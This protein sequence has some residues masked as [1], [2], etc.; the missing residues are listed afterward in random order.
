[1]FGNVVNR[2]LM[3][4]IQVYIEEQG[5]SSE[6]APPPVMPT[7]TF[8]FPN[9]NITYNVL[10]LSVCVLLLRPNSYRSYASR[11]T[12]H[13][14]VQQTCRVPIVV[15]D[16]KTSCSTLVQCRVVII[17]STNILLFELGWSMFRE[18]GDAHDQPRFVSRFVMICV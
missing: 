8:N 5:S 14:Q 11:Q 3:I 18:V 12:Q 6:C 15:Y 7:V 9:T 1:M 16:S 4:C 17:L 13:C 10:C 2:F